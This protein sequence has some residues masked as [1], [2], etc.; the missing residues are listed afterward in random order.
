MGKWKGSED[1]MMVFIGE[2]WVVIVMTT[3]TW[4]RIGMRKWVFF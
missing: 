4:R 2:G 1:L 3:V